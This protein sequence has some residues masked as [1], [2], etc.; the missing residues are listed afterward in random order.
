VAYALLRRLSTRRYLAAK[1]QASRA[2]WRMVIIYSSFDFA[3]G[4]R[5]F[6]LTIVYLVV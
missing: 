3:P 2:C 1:A 5:F 4:R 6:L